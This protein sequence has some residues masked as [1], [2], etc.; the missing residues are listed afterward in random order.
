MSG[1]QLSSVAKN[2]LSKAIG[3]FA[4]G[5][6]VQSSDVKN[7]FSVDPSIAQKLQEEVRA[8]SDVLSKINIIPVVA[9]KG[10]KISIGVNG[11]ISSRTDLSDE[12]KERKAKVAHGL[13]AMEYEL[14][15][16]DTDYAIPYSVL[17]S[18]AHVSTGMAKMIRSQ[19]KQQIADDRVMCGFNGTSVAANSNR[20]DNPLLQD[21][22]I[23]WPQL[24][25][26]QN[27]DN[28]FSEDVDDEGVSLGTGKIKVGEGQRYK[29]LDQVVTALKNAIPKHKRKGL[30]AL[31]SEDLME[32]YEQFVWAIGGA[33]P[34]EK[35]KLLMDKLLNK[36]GKLDYETPEHFPDGTVMVVA[37][38]NLSI[39]HQEGS[40]QA[41]TIDNPKRKQLEDYNTRNEGYVIEDVEAITMAENI[42]FEDKAP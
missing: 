22:N 11:A 34:S 10:Q 24:L 14:Y 2:G 39:Y 42:V 36:L 19:V 16:V 3:Q 6:G 1:V 26:N 21:L 38:K 30:V 33:K 12:N 4:K 5:F 17:N 15:E 41:Q 40:W 18:W 28:V 9:I 27:S 20:I 29:N 32:E 25:K 8:V 23:G 13:K 7:G 31:V 37:W 35:E